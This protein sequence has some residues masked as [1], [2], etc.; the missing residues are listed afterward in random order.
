MH[1][2][3]G[4]IHLPVARVCNIHCMY[5]ERRIG[6]FYHSMRPG[7]AARVIAPG[8]VTEYI[9]KALSECPSIE[10]IA[11]AGPGEPLAN[12]ATFRALAIAHRNFP[13]MKLCVCTNGLLLPDKVRELRKL[14]VRFLTVTINAVDPK[15]GAMIYSFARYRGR[16]YRGEKA[17]K[18]LA[19]KQFAGVALAIRSGMDVKINSVY[20]PGINDEDLP[21]IADAAA[22][23][24][25]RIMNVM[26]LIP[27]GR[28]A[29]RKG[30]TCAQLRKMRKRCER[31]IPQFRLCKQCRAD[32][33]GIPGSE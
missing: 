22:S 7:V 26:P 13:G 8:D 21:A 12:P 20:I 2:K 11:V 14:G 24:G 23:L 19:K 33:C 17:A 32:A 15:T 30:P 18:L 4:R 16:I 25:V 6:E 5:C 29:G 9:R 27:S 28:L 31:Y 10:V 3:V 1:S